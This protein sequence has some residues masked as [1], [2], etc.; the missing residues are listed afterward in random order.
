[1]WLTLFRFI[2]SISANAFRSNKRQT[3]KQA[4]RKPVEYFMLL[5][6]LFPFN[7][8]LC[9]CFAFLFCLV[10]LFH[11][12]IAFKTTAKI[13]SHDQWGDFSASSNK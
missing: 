1:M 12:K 8:S 9:F 3:R 11:L 10:F 7:F 5:L 6:M 4:T 2:G 13:Y